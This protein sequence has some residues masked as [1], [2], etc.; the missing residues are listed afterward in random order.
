MI[1]QKAPSWSSTAYHNNEQIDIS[2]EE[3]TGKWYILYWYPLDFTL[4]CPTEIREFQRLLHAFEREDTAIIG[5][6]TDSF[7]SHRAWFSETPTF[8][9][10]ITHPVLADTS[11]HVTRAFGML[12]EARGVAFRGT[13]IVDDKGIIRSEAAND[14]TVGRNPSEVLRTLEALRAGGVC[15]VNWNKGDAFLGKL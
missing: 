8:F 2:S 11:H 10:P 7:H 4:I 3:Y 6:S 9:K 1:L 14:T 5:C 13:V 12:N 15:G